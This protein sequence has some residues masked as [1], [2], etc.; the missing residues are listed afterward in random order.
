[1]SGVMNQ[2]PNSTKSTG[3]YQYGGGLVSDGFPGFEK[4]VVV[5][6]LRF[7]DPQACV[8][9]CSIRSPVVVL[10]LRSS[11][12]RGSVWP[13]V[14]CDKYAMIVTPGYPELMNSIRGLHTW[15]FF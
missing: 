4:D 15:L 9:C 1:M 8:V 14:V 2:N 7:R 13:W 12:R 6:F 5:H 3:R 11:P 10:L